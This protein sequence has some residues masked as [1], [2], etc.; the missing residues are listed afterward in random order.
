[1]YKVGITGGIGSGKS[2]V[3]RLFEQNGIAVY[4]SDARAKALMA[5]DA[6][7]REQLVEAFGA[8]CYN[9]QGLDRAYLAGRVF[10]DEAELQRLNGIVHP[11]VKEDFRRWADVQRGAYVV[12][13]SAILFESGFDTEVNTTLAVMAPM[14]E[15]LRRTVER[16]GVDREAVRRRMEHQ[17][18]DD[19]LHARAARTIV[20]LRMDYL[21][22]DVE[23]LHK[24]YCYEASL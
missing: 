23:Q 11:A 10:G 24:I 20:N 5:E 21:E 17:L 2:T 12:L 13:E 6:T 14:E 9:E 8:E 7:L 16:D 3:C 1:M 22:S 15:R 4:D 19:E 18:S